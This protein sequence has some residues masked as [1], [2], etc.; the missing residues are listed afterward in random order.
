MWPDQQRS[1]ATVKSA[2][3]NLLA[4]SCALSWGEKHPDFAIVVKGK[5]AADRCF[6]SRSGNTQ[7]HSRAH[8]Q[9]AVLPL[10]GPYF[11]PQNGDRKAFEE[12]PFLN[13]FPQVVLP[14]LPVVFCGPGKS[15]LLQACARSQC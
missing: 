7:N 9:A 3:M 6:P 1:S 13:I 8:K 2:N 4:F 12:L 15:G 14:R 11:I 10:C 5:A